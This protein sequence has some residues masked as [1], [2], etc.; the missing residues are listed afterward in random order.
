MSKKVEISERTIIF[1]LLL[2]ALIW[3]VIQT[4]D[5]IL[6][7]FISFIIMSALKPL[8]NRL[9]VLRFPRSLAIVVVY[10]VI[11]LAVGAVVAGIVPS[12][13]DQTTR[14]I[15]QFSGAVASNQYL[16]QHQ[17]ELTSQ[18]L[19]SMGTIPTSVIRLASGLFG[20]VLDVVSTVVISFYLLMER[21]KIDALLEGYLNRQKAQKIAKI[22]S[23]VEIRLGGWIRGEL[24]LMLCV[25]VMTYIGLRI[26]GLETALPL[27][28]LAGMLE[29]IPSIGPTFSAIPAVI[30]ALTVHPLMAVSTVALY[31]LVQF[32]ENNLLVPQIMSRST[33]V[34]PLVSMIALMI[35]FRLAGTAGAILALPL[36]LV[37]HV[38]SPNLFPSVESDKEK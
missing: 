15:S 13:I 11:W 3:L 10:T 28:I 7:L 26:L 22:I 27:A 21:R 5:I 38:A 18:L 17:Q 8:V 30:V 33:G 36:I 19:S 1:S 29:I 34:N 14:L 37:V 32:L 12:L 23:D 6:I 35:G 2:I 16:N 24:L 9:E 25:G 31:V 4:L 20:N